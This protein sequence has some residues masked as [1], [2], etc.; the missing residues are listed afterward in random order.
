MAV[1]KDIPGFP[2]Y[3]LICKKESYQGNYVSQN[4]EF[5]LANMGGTSFGYGIGLQ[6]GDRFSDGGQED[7][8]HWFLEVLKVNYEMTVGSNPSLFD[9]TGFM[10]NGMEIRLGLGIHAFD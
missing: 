3:Y 7:G 9:Q 8:S 5:V 2:N 6:V 1:R 4:E 10:P